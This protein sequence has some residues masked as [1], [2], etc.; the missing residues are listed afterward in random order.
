PRFNPAE[1]FQLR[2]VFSSA[3]AN[4]GFS[5][6]LFDLQGHRG[7][8][9]LRPENT[10]PAFETALDIGVHSIETDLHLTRDGVPILFH[11]AHISPRLCRL[12]SGSQAPDPAAQPPI[13]G[14]T[15]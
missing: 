5:M 14:L 9:G 3:S 11:D 7:A 2:G 10:L 1:V 13:S 12:V 6:P 15:L 4:A 8:R